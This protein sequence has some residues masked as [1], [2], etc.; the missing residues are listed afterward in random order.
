[1]RGF[2]GFFEFSSQLKPSTTTASRT[3]SIALYS[4]VAL[5]CC[6][7]LFVQLGGMLICAMP[8]DAFVY[9]DGAQRLAHGQVQH[10]DF[11]TPMG[12]LCN[13]IPYLGYKASG[14]FAGSVDMGCLFAAAFLLAAASYV[15]GTRFTVAAAL[16]IV[17]FF[18][19]LAVVPLGVESTPDLV[20]TAMFYNRLGWIALTL[21][22]LFFLEPR[23]TAMRR[24]PLD[25]VCLASL[26][27]FGFYL[28]VSYAL[29]G[30]AFLPVM[31][32]GSR[33]NRK[34]ALAAIAV[35][36]VVIGSVELAYGFHRGYVEDLRQTLKACGTNRGT[37]APKLMAN[38]REFLLAAFAVAVGFRSA[39]NKLRYLAMAGYIAAAGLAIIDQN[40][41]LRG[42]ICLIAL[43]LIPQEL[44]RRSCWESRGAAPTE[45]INVLKSMCCL[46]L[47]LA[48][49]VQPV[50]YR[51]TCMAIIRSVLTQVRP[52]L[53]G[54]LSGMVFPEHL[55]SRLHASSSQEGS[56]SSASPPPPRTVANEA[57]RHYLASLLDG[58]ELLETVETSGKSVIDFDFVTPFSFILNLQPPTGD[59]TCIDYWRTM[60]EASY[61]PVDE[62]LGSVDFVMEPRT[63]VDPE[64][65]DFLMRT[66]GSYLDRHFS[67]VGESKHWVLWKRTATSD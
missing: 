1:M 67:R 54:Q 34:L 14:G 28:K 58:V 31:G 53:P 52:D 51:C 41:H 46:A 66:Y 9:L 32:F 40:T 15:L 42:V 16:P 38:I 37:M 62:M 44:I 39:P 24:L 4:A 61:A 3:L 25:V 48:F 17:I 23:D 49:V 60:S 12:V 65:T 10:V 30:L 13:L 50:A 7:F 20:T 5:T 35:V 55:W 22:F 57:E 56:P 36:L 11:H 8:H 64:T 59:Q 27:L 45:N 43:F 19:L 21:I 47:L 2:D 63:P 18:C 33:Y 29:V 26:L 6:Y